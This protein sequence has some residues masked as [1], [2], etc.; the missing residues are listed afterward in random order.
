MS[1]MEAYAYLLWCI[2]LGGGLIL[3]I[4]AWVG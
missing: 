1:R 2:A 4:L 3:V